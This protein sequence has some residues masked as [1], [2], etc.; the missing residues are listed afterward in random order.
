MRLTLF[1][2]G[3]VVTN[4]ELAYWSATSGFKAEFAVRAVVEHA[5]DQLVVAP[6]AQH[7]DDDLEETYEAFRGRLAAVALDADAW[8]E[9]C[10]GAL[11]GGV[12]GG[13]DTFGP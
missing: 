4:H 13:G 10:G 1:A 9:L 5:T 6:A 7:L 3:S 8:G 2:C 12:E 11:E